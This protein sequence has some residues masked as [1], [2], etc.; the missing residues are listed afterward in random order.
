MN[1]QDKKYPLST[2]IVGFNE[3]NIIEDC[4]RSIEFCDE[5]IFVDLGSIDRTKDIARKFTSNIFTH[6]RVPTV[7]II[8]QEFIDKIKYD[9]LL[10][11]DPDERISSSLVDEIKMFVENG[12]P[13]EIGGYNMPWI[14]Y[15]KNKRL[16]GTIWGGVKYKSI[17]LHKKKYNFLPIVHRGR[18]VLDGYRNF[19]VKFNGDNFIYHY[20]MNSYSA[21]LEKHWRYIKIEPKSRYTRGIRTSLRQIIFTPFTAFK[22]S[23]WDNKAY[24]DKFTGLF[25]SLFWSWYE[26][27]CLIGLYFY[28]KKRDK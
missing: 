15:F 23:F 20:W 27:C 3:E 11:L 1:K 22:S 26:T 17:L 25:L 8:H 7:E 28:Q 14:F 24:L 21:L 16:R 13:E 6:E 4:F 9:W 2:I 5:I 19:H 10:I 18:N 12:S